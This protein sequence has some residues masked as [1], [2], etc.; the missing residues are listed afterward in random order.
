[1]KLPGK[2]SLLMERSL[3]DEIVSMRYVMLLKDLRIIN[4]RLSLVLLRSSGRVGIEFYGQVSIFPLSTTRPQTFESGRIDFE[5]LVDS[6]AFPFLR[7]CFSSHS[8]I[9]SS[10]SNTIC[11]AI[12]FTIGTV[13]SLRV[14]ILRSCRCR[15]RWSR[16]VKIR[17][18]LDTRWARS[19]ILSKFSNGGMFSMLV[20]GAASDIKQVIL[21]VM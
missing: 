9:L 11:N 15:G 1:L 4:L 10:S 21:G 18:S 12:H 3:P 19:S 14:V 16:A 8:T 2:C 20:M 5:L 6:A 17:W 13:G 7:F